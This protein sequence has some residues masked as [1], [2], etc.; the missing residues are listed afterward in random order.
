MEFILMVLKFLLLVLLPVSVMSCSDSKQD[1]RLVEIEDMVSYSP[2]EALQRLDSID[3]TTLSE[4]DRHYFDFLTIKARD[5]AYIKH[6]SD[7]LI[8]DVIEYY[9]NSSDKVRLAESLYY[10]GR[11]FSDMGDYPKALSYFQNALDEMSDNPADI[12]LKSRTLSQT[13]DILIS[14][15]LLNE[16]RQYSEQALKYDIKANDSMSIIY[17]YEQLGTIDLQSKQYETAE[18]HYKKAIHIARSLNNSDSISINVPLASI[19]YYNG[20]ID[21]AIAIIRPAIRGIDSISRNTALA[22]ASLIYKEKNVKDTALLYAKELIS[23]NDFLNRKTGYSVLLSDEILPLLSN[24]TIIKYVKNYR[25]EIETYLNKNG[26][27]SALM[28]NS[29][30][31]YQTHLRDKV[32]AEK[33]SIRLQNRNMTLILMVIVL[34][35]IIICIIVINKYRTSKL[36]MALFTIIQMRMEITNNTIFKLQYVEHPVIGEPKQEQS[37]LCNYNQKPDTGFLDSGSIKSQIRFELNALLDSAPLSKDIPATIIESGVYSRIYKEIASKN[38]IQENDSIWRELEELIC[39]RYPM[40]KM[41]LNNL[42]GHKLNKT[43][44][45]ILFMVKIGI[46][47]TDM[48][49][50]LGR[51]KSTVSFNRHS[52]AKKLFG[53]KMKIDKIDQLIRIM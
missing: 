27:Q 24:D 21:S 20:N 36:Q 5:K 35:F 23:K 6:T 50:L 31:N 4:G 39:Q 44:L 51:S 18:K 40:F 43:E 34:L 11:V 37:L 10:G 16:A 32:K 9:A 17:D 13:S 29:F 22:C 46:A 47:P 42:G 7:S 19:K 38:I 1:P 53:E 45:H 2:R 41:R 28:Q 49:V 30:Y 26:N 8:L 33:A 52:I 3:G 12:N 25:D 48:S 14:L 15:R